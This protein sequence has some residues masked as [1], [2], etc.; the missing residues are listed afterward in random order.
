MPFRMNSRVWRT[1]SLLSLS[2]KH[3]RK[4]NAEYPLWKSTI[5]EH[6]S[7]FMCSNETPLSLPLETYLQEG[8]TIPTNLKFW[9][10]TSANIQQQISFTGPY[11][12][13]SGLGTTATNSW[14][15]FAVSGFGARWSSGRQNCFK[16]AFHLTRLYIN[17]GIVQVTYQDY[18][19]CLMW[20]KSHF[21]AWDYRDILVDVSSKSSAI[22]VSIKLHTNPQPSLLLL[23]SF[24][25]HSLSSLIWISP[26]PNSTLGILPYLRTVLGFL[27]LHS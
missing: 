15:G 3:S 8:P 16:K 22:Y 19:K 26:A 13:T 1:E 9:M 4:L 25:S 18:S 27:L 14:A 21:N 12:H 5:C 11:G 10:Q 7:Q 2:K 6:F 17:S 20:D 23:I 24:F